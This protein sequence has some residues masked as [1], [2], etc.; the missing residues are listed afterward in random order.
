MSNIL[1]SKLEQD[2]EK[3]FETCIHCG[4][5]LSACPTY[6]QTGDESQS[7]R[8]R[9][10]L[11]Q[12]V[13]DGRLPF[14]DLVP[15]LETCLGCMACETACPSQVKYHHVLEAGRL[16]A[17]AQGLGRFSLLAQ[18]MQAVLKQDALLSLVTFGMKLADALGFRRLLQASWMPRFILEKT[19][20]W[21]PIPSKGLDA[22]LSV[23]DPKAEIALHLGCVMKHLMPDVH[24]ACLDVLTAMG[25]S[26]TASPLGCCGAL[27]SH[28]GL[29]KET[30]A[31]MKENAQ[32]WQASSQQTTLSNAGGCGAMLK[33]YAHLATHLSL[34]SADTSQKALAEIAQATEDIH[35]F[36]WTHH[37]RLPALA[38]PTPMVVT[39]QGSC[40]L[41]HAQGVTE[42]PLALLQQVKNLTLSPMQNASSCCGSAGIYNLEH[43]DLAEA[44]AQDKVQAILATGASVVVVGN[45][46]CLIQL[47]A[48]LA[49][50]APTAK[51]E[52]LHPMQLLAEAVKA[53]PTQYQSAE[54]PW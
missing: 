38:L 48:S 23:A 9:I 45:P 53:C 47:K 46:G 10:H 2:L 33:D 51:I 18:V 35:A 32:A 26:V 15:A 22:R 6:V 28:H 43:P 12:A 41:T 5:C 31:C 1:E 24:N 36:I 3:A 16:T 34:D 13:H 30:E 25:F 40:H 7:P 52:V 44:I 4:M 54:Q 14:A 27:A 50:Y 37:Q 29:A 42:A 8:G 39:Y 20:F 49:V 17:H 21:M 19:R 11:S